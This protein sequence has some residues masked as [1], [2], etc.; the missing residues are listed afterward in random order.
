VTT[1]D[2]PDAQ[3]L[4]AAIRAYPYWYHRIELPGG[5][6]TPGWAPISPESYHVPADLTGKRVLDIG[7][8]DGFW[9]FEALKRGAREVVAIDDFSD[10]L[11]ESG[12]KVRQA[13]ETFDLCRSA[14]GW[15]E[16]RCSRTEMSVYD[17]SEDRLG[18]FDVVFFFGMFYHLRHPLLALDRIAA[19]ADDLICVESA[20]LDDMSPYRGGLGHGYAGGQMVMEFYP[21]DQ[22][23][24]NHTNWWVPTLMLLGN[25]I[26]SAGFRHVDI[27]KL[28]ENP[29]DLSLCRGFAQGWKRGGPADVAAGQIASSGPR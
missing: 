22:Y 17:I 29:T 3:A 10:L 12:P 15:D 5:V 23:G 6:V 20:I 1:A 4:K 2:I 13:W 8:W 16:T 26:G 7:A 19:V 21:G 14:F 28:V 9:T 18:R 24:R 11:G 25:M 27:W